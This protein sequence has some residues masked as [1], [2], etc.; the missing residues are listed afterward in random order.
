MAS[1]FEISR[2]N[3]AEQAYIRRSMKAEMLEREDEFELARL[4]RDKNDT[5]ALHRLVSAYARLVISTAQRFRHFG[6][7]IGDLIQE[8]NVGL[9]H[10]A[11]RFE[12]AREVR[13]STYAAW[14]IRSSMQDYILR[15][16]S[17]VRTGTTAA[18]K[19]LFF[20]LRRLR[21][22]I[23]SRNGADT[24]GDADRNRI[25]LELHVKLSDVEAMEQRLSGADQSLN[26]TI[27]ETGED[28]IGDFLADERPTPEDVVIGSRDSNTRSQ[29]LAL[30]L[31]E[32]S[33]REQRIIRSRRLSEDED[34][35]TLEDLGRDLGV[36]KERVRQLESRALEKLKVSMLKHVASPTELFFPAV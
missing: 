35:A 12:P 8:G 24:L 27:G 9:M 13:F 19:S 16:W 26:Y 21:A 7:P 25:A 1:R 31:A 18:Q 6:L 5:K 22:R 14:W 36:S 11:A 34:A 17:I 32:L 3:K 23:L 20:N 4:W 10:A 29:W 30:A 33:P 28:E 15:N 2:D